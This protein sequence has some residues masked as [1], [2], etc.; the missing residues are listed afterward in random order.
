MFQLKKNDN[1]WKIYYDKFNI[2][3]L[4]QGKNL[5]PKA[6]TKKQQNLKHNFNNF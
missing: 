4:S 6:K 5:I 1:K 2:Y 3:L